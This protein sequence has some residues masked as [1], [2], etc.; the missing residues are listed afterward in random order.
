M[1][2]LKNLNPYAPFLRTVMKDLLLQNEEQTKQEET[3]NLNS[4]EK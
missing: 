2:G 4:V 1:Q 3:K